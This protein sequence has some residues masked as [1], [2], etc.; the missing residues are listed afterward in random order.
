MVIGGGPI[1]I[2]MSQAFARLGVKTTVLQK[3]DRIL[4]RDE[5]DLVAR[6]TERL[7][8]DGVDLVLDV[9]TDGVA[10]EDGMKV[11]RGTARR[12]GEWRGGDSRG[13]RSQAQRG[14]AGPGGGRRRRRGRAAWRWTARCA[15]R[16]KSVYAAG[17]L[18]GRFLFTHSAGY[19]AAGAIRNMFFPGSSDAT[20]FVPWCTYTDPELAHAGLTDAEAREE[21]GDDVHVWRHDLSHSDRARADS[22]PRTARSGSSPRKGADGGRARAHRRMPAR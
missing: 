14:G 5:P 6:L 7:R 3:G 19:E 15:P 8:A 2:E 9:E 22:A 1:S 21:H 18:A 13:R 16:V 4:P 17:D 12:A 10:V 20:D 11:V